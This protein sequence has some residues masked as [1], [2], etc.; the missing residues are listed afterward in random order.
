MIRL[1]LLGALVATPAQ[2]L[3]PE[4]LTA[5]QFQSQRIQNMVDRTNGQ[6][7][8]CPPVRNQ[9]CT[10]LPEAKQGRGNAEFACR[11][12]ERLGKRWLSAHGTLARFGGEWDF[13]SA[14][15][16]RCKNL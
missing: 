14:A 5:A 9:D 3:P 16:R 4:G 7:P 12:Q 15:L 1:A 2:A 11:F 10:P 13:N 8:V 6:G